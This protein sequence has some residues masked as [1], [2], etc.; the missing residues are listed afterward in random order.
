MPKQPNKAR[1]RGAAQA[2]KS[3]FRRVERTLDAIAHGGSPLGTI[4]NV[5]DYM[6]V[7]F[8]EDLGIT[9][10]V[11]VRDLW[12]HEDLGE[13]R[14]LFE[15]KIPMHGSGLYHISPLP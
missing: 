4:S 13:F 2:P 9:G 7:N 5:A 12:S 8:C 11:K 3:L 6:A 15:K 1:S 10:K 14:G